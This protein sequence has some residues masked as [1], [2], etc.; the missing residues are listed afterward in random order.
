MGVK[1]GMKYM[2]NE[3]YARVAAHKSRNDRYCC[4]LEACSSQIS[5]R[6]SQGRASRKIK[7]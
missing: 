1:G 5:T 6:G 7:N 4:L 3:C 2:L